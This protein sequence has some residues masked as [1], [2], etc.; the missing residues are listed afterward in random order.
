M[1]NF[2]QAHTNLL[3]WHALIL[4][5]N[6]YVYQYRDTYGPKEGHVLYAQL[7]YCENY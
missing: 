6:H 4:R 1:E 2:V 7:C 3:L 5:Y